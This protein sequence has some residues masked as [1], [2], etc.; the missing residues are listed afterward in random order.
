MK[1]FSKAGGGVLLSVLLLFAGCGGGGGGNNSVPVVSAELPYTVAAVGDTIV[2][3]E[4]S[5]EDEETLTAT[6]AVYK[7]TEKVADVTDGTFTPSS[8]GDYTVRYT[9]TDSAG[10]AG[11]AE[12][13]L[14]I[15]ENVL[16]TAITATIPAGKA[17]KSV[18]A[19]V[20]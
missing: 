20:R 14:H 4:A 17:W 8:A 12:I 11:T 9:A 13:S 1:Q 15:V 10:Q 6:A 19:A 2:L 5:V 18:W 7:G 16:N 3:P